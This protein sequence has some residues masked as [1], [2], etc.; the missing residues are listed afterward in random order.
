MNDRDALISQLQEGRPRILLVDDDLNI[1]TGL[2][3]ILEDA[4]YAVEIANSAEEGLEHLERR[5]FSVMIVDYSLPDSNGIELSRKIRPSHP[6]LEI[7]LMSGHDQLEIRG[8]TRTAGLFGAFLKKPVDIQMITTAIERALDREFDALRIP[9]VPVVSAPVEPPPPAGPARAPTPAPRLPPVLISR[10]PVPRPAPAV[11]TRPWAAWAAVALAGFGFGWFAK[12][13]SVRPFTAA[14][15]LSHPAAPSAPARPALPPK[16]HAAL[17]PTAPEADAD[18]SSDEEE[19]ADGPLVPKKRDVVS[20][21]APESLPHTAPAPSEK[22]AAAP[23]PAA[24]A[25]S[26]PVNPRAGL[27]SDQFKI[28]LA[29]AKDL[30][31]ASPD[32]PQAAAVLLTLMRDPNSKRRIAAIETASAAEPTAG[33]VISALGAALY[34]EESSVAYAAAKALGHLGPAAAP[35]VPNLIQAMN[36]KS[37]DTKF[38]GAAAQEALV[39]VGAPAV[40]ELVK[41]LKNAALRSDLLNVLGKIGPDAGE[42]IPALSALLDDPD[43]GAAAKAA[44]ARIQPAAANPPENSARAAP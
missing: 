13:I 4:G 35:A 30:L 34:D 17:V 8:I 43:S 42:A 1:T 21:P 44:L 27:D 28:R 14:P 23:K 3:D 38:V 29:S 7:I 33:E 41:G 25:P 9:R 24:P 36:Y 37:S 11:R 31:R 19:S 18:S 26:E 12:G 39:R 16:D 15:P 22:P 10:P 20:K 6:L 40:G 2:K 5:T 32:D